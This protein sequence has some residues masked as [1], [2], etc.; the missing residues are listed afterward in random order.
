MECSCWTLRHRVQ[1]CMLNRTKHTRFAKLIRLVTNIVVTRI[2]IPSTET[3][4]VENDFDY[5]NNDLYN[6]GQGHTIESCRTNCRSVQNANYFSLSSAWG[7][8]CKSSANGRTPQAG[9]VSGELWCNTSGDTDAEYEISKVIVQCQF[10]VGRRGI[11]I[12]VM[13]L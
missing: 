10:Q 3:C 8:N 4:L 9:T 5:P 11:L 13:L 12:Q 6:H 1:L 2:C 7:C